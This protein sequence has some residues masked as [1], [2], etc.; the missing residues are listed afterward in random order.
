MRTIRVM[1]ARTFGR[2]WP[3]PTTFLAV[4]G[5][6]ALSGGFFTV[7]LMRGDGGTTPVAA[8]WAVSAVP[9]LPVLAALLTAVISP[10]FSLPHPVM[11]IPMYL[12]LVN[13]SNIVLRLRVHW[14]F[15]AKIQR[16]LLV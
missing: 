8:L 13:L 3:S 7:A 12:C 5:F 10:M 15:P 2:L 16:R 1:F 6:L 4:A 9:F 11:P 14:D